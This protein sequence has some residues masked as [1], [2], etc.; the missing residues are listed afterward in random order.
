MNASYQSGFSIRNHPAKAVAARA[1][2]DLLPARARGTVIADRRKTKS[3]SH[4][5]RP[6]ESSGGASRALPTRPLRRAQ[7]GTF[8]ME[9][10]LSY[11]CQSGILLEI[12]T[13]SLAGMELY[14]KPGQS[15]RVSTI[16]V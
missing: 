2:R 6:H 10:Q 14:L 16:C 15:D 4:C 13:E 9:F 3:G 1:C 11:L 8:Q 7:P 12:E 5:D